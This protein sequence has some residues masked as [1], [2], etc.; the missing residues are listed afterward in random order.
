M[1]LMNEI[2]LKGTTVLLATHSRDI[3]ERQRRRTLTL[4]KGKLVRD[5]PNGGYAI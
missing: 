1:E 4:R 3:V 5:D 2:N